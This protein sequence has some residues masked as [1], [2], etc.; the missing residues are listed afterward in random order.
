MLDDDLQSKYNLKFASRYKTSSNKLTTEHLF[1]LH[2][3]QEGELEAQIELWEGKLINMLSIFQV[4]FI[5]DF[6]GLKY[7]VFLHLE[8]PSFF[9]SL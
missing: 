9:E 3:G 8:C 6:T 1:S 7:A 2:G 4:V 5:L